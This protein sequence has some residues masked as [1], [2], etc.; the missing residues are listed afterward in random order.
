MKVADRYTFIRQKNQIIIFI[1]VEIVNE[2]SRKFYKVLNIFEAFE[3]LCEN[4]R[5]AFDEQMMLE[6][7]ELVLPD[8]LFIEL[9]KVIQGYIDEIKD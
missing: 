5:E 2:Q 9:R 8:V 1:E 7:I 6:G 4:L 3:V